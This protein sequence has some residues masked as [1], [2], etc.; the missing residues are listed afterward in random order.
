MIQNLG[1]GESIGTAPVNLAA[2]VN[3]FPTARQVGATS[4]GATPARG[5]NRKV[6]IDAKSFLT[7]EM[8]LNM[9]HNRGAASDWFCQVRQG[10]G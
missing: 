1:C 6:V 7:V 5:V 9:L 2:P 8:T 3:L 4:S 10:R